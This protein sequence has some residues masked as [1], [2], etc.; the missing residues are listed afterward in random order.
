MKH[1][2]FIMKKIIVLNKNKK[3]G[4]ILKKNVYMNY[5]KNLN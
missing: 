1:V 2:L 5:H 3:I 4:F